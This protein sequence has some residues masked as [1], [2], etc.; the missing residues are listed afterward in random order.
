MGLAPGREPRYHGVRLGDWLG[1]LAEPRADPSRSAI[2]FDTSPEAIEAIRGIGTNA[3]PFLVTWLGY[4]P[5]AWKKKLAA[6]FGPNNFLMKGRVRAWIR[7][8]PPDERGV[9]LITAFGI[10]GTNAS[11]AAPEIIQIIKTRRLRR[12]KHHWSDLCAGVCGISRGLPDSQENCAN[13]SEF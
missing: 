2:I 11:S 6:A 13:R 4:E 9:G 12:R 3:T 1:R 10:L 5:P 8:E 7:D